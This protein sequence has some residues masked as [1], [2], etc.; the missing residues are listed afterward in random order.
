MGHYIT[1]DDYAR[2]SA[3][4]IHAAAL[5]QRVRVYGWDTY[6]AATQPLQTQKNRSHWRAIA[7][8]NGITPST[9]YHRINQLGWEIKRAV[10]EPL[11]P[12]SESLRR[13][14]ETRRKYAPEWFA[15]AEQYGISPALFRERVRELGWDYQ[16][17]AT[18]PKMSKSESG[19]LGKEALLKRVP[20]KYSVR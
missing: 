11:I 15:L 18:E 13:G 2:A 19:R 20:Y 3:N 9:F 10:T 4:G 8:K 1:P 14:T 5:E 6:R 17:A 7:E 12:K 16:K